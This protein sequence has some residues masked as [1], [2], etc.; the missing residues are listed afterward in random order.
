MVQIRRF[1]ELLL[2]LLGDLQ[3]GVGDRCAWTIMSFMVKGGSSLRPRRL[4]DH[5]PAASSRIIVNVTKG[6]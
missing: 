4:Y 2:N 3:Q 5:A 6:R 1:L